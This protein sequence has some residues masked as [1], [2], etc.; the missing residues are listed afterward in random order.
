MTGRGARQRR[1]DRRRSQY[2]AEP[3]SPRKDVCGQAFNGCGHYCPGCGIQWDQNEERPAC[4]LK[5]VAPFPN[6]DPRYPPAHTLSRESNE[7]ARRTGQQ[8]PKEPL[9]DFETYSTWPLSPPSFIAFTMYCAETD[10]ELETMAV[11][12]LARLSDVEH[13]CEQRGQVAEIRKVVR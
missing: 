2:S 4:P 11:P 5:S 10:R 9:L 6:E 8:M 12:I 7:R 13:Y 1:Q 3:P